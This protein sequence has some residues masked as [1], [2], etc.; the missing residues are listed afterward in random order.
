[1]RLNSREDMAG[2]RSRWQSL[3]KGDRKGVP[4]CRRFLRAPAKQIMGILV[5]QINLLHRYSS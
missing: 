3:R 4:C 5:T 1:M 2:I